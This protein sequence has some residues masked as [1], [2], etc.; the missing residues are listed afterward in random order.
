MGLRLTEGIDLA[1][2]GARFSM[3]RGVMVDEAALARLCGLG[4][5]WAEDSRIGVTPA[6]RGLLDALLA[7]VVAD[8]LV[9]A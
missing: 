8:A 9:A 5:M 7:E 4:L 3:A 6:G 2:I 1:A